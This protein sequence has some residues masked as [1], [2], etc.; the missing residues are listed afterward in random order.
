MFKNFELTIK[1]PLTG[2]WCPQDS[3]ENSDTAT[4]MVQVE[5]VESRPPRWVE[6]FA[7]QQFD[8]KTEQSFTVRA[9]D[10]DTGINGTIDY[11]LIRNEN[12]K[13]SLERFIT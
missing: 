7:V 11:I 8:E 12:G 13:I 3:A 4:M 10:G 9:I 2:Y 1:L 5:N 6:I